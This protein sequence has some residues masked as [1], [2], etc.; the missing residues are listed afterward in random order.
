[1][2]YLQF[3]PSPSGNLCWRSSVSYLAPARPALCIKSTVLSYC[4]KRW[5]N[6]YNVF[7]LKLFVPALFG[8]NVFSFVKARVKD[9]DRSILLSWFQWPYPNSDYIYVCNLCPWASVTLKYFKFLGL[10]D[11]FIT[12]IGVQFSNYIWRNK[13]CKYK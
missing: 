10:Q 3:D 5:K 12:F 11:F 13:T 8:M 1:M 9:I 2:C 6:G 4:I 7:F